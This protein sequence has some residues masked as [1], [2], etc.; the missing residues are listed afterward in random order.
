MGSGIYTYLHYLLR[1]FNL[2]SYITIF[3]VGLFSITFLPYSVP[4]DYFAHLDA[5]GQRIDLDQRPELTKGSVDFV[6][7]TEY[8]VRPP[9]PPLYFF[10]IDV[11]IAAVRSGM[12]EVN[13]SIQ[14]FRLLLLLLFKG[15]KIIH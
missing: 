13:I 7:P 2:F 14:F 3:P 4:G 10:L 15:N 11:S 6:A 1:K 12:L 9:M 8:M 5:T